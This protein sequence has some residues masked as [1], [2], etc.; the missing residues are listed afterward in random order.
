MLNRAF[1]ARQGTIEHEELKSTI[2]LIT[3]ACM[4][5]AGEIQLVARRAFYRP[6]GNLS[7]GQLADLI[8]DALT[9]ACA[10]DAR[11]ILI[12]ITHV[13]GF[14]SPGPAYRRW[15]ARRWARTAGGRLRVAVVARQEYICPEKT[16]LLVA[17]QEGLSAQ[18]GHSEI[19]ALAWLDSWLA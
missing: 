1:G 19:Y 6:I 18:I 12:D 7:A 17:A 11:D 13:V 9:L 5:V 3:I 4:D 2:P 16:G 8:D 14:E 10:R 15:V